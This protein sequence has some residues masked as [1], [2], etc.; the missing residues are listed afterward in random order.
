MGK[1]ADL[2]LC[3][4]R[5]LERRSVCRYWFR[6]YF[7]N[8]RCDRQRGFFALSKTFFAGILT[9]FKENWRGAA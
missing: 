5:F 3:I 8:S 2:R 9:Y 7:S 1:A 6:V 4:W